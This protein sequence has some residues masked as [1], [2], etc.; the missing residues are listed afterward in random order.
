MLHSSAGLSGGV[1]LMF[2]YRMFLDTPKHTEG[3]ELFIQRDEVWLYL[4]PIGMKIAYFIDGVESYEF[5]VTGLRHD[6]RIGEE[7]HKMPQGA[8]M[9]SDFRWRTGHGLRY[10]A[11]PLD[12]E[13]DTEQ[14]VEVLEA[15]GWNMIARPHLENQEQALHNFRERVVHE[16]EDLHLTREIVSEV[17][18]LSPE[19]LRNLKALIEKKLE[20]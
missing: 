10:W 7:H 4:P 3:G 8:I 14:L 1:M 5:T 11:G 2:K 13:Y 16:N 15:T 9:C 18:E 19:Q 17:E 20:E 6:V 12:V